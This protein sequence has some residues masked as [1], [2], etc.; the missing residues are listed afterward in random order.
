MANCMDSLWT[1]GPGSLNSDFGTGVVR[2]TD[3]NVV[4]GGYYD[5]TGITQGYGWLIKSDPTDGGQIWSRTYTSGNGQGIFLDI[6]S[7]SD[8]GFVCGGWMRDSVTLDQQF[9]LYRMNGSGDSLWSRA[10]GHQ[11]AN[12]GR[13]VVQAT[14]GGYAIAGRAHSLP[15]GFGET[16][17][18]ILKTNTNGDSVWSQIIGGPFEDSCF[19]MILTANGNYLMIG[20][21]LTDS[22]REGRVAE[23]SA[24]GAVLWS[25]AYTPEVSTELESV[26]ISD[27]GYLLCG[28]ASPRNG[29]YDVLIME[30]DLTGNELWHRTFN[31]IPGR[32]DYATT[33]R[34]D[35][36]GSYYVFGHG[37]RSGTTE[38]DVFAMR[39]SA[40]GDSLSTIW[41]GNAVDEEIHDAILASNGIL[42]T[43]G[44]ARLPGNQLELQGYGIRADTCNGRPCSFAR[45]S[46]V[47]STLI[48]PT[49]RILMTWTRSSD[50][51]GDPIDFVFHMESNYAFALEPSDT[52]T[53]DTFVWVTVPIPVDP[54]DE[55]FDC[56]WSVR[57]TDGQDTVD[58]TNRQGYFRVDLPESVGDN[59]VLPSAFE[60]TAY[61]N[62]FNSRTTLSFALARSERITLVLYDIQGRTVK[63]LLDESIAAGTHT[64]SFDGSG[65]TSGIYFVSM[66]T[67]SRTDLSKIVLL[68]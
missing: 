50:P 29:T 27:N 67:P 30:I 45:L 33:I 31:L 10:Y 66:Q 62:P 20:N 53:S 40:C 6:A 68:K 35:G 37:F 51:D 17:W 42:V 63:T 5:F 32:N 56:H 58:A 54:L 23:I 15:G 38:K 57:A 2:A 43:A 55:I 60:L 36:N 13:T 18:W 26:I 7:T 16:D 59:I 65:L 39:V 8:G 49:P 64:I 19:D 41:I 34:P 1:I 4:F 28:S 24:T 11:F 47:D 3:N 52:V 61:P 44:L 46:P 9:W 48:E 14:D 21:G 12:Q 25:A 22:T